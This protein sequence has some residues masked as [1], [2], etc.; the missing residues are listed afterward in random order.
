MFDETLRE[1]AVGRFFAVANSILGSLAKA[2]RPLELVKEHKEHVE[3]AMKY[4][5]AR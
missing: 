5:R 1:D 2:V 3:A 4:V